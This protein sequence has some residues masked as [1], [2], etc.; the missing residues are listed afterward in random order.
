MERLQEIHRLEKKADRLQSLADRRA[1]INDIRLQRF[2]AA[3]DNPVMQFRQAHAIWLNNQHIS[4]IIPQ[5]IEAIQEQQ[6]AIS[7]EGLAE[8][9]EQGLILSGGYER[10]SAEHQIPVNPQ[11]Q[12]EPQRAEI[13]PHE[14]KP[15]TQR[16]RHEGKREVFAVTLPDGQILESTSKRI[17]KVLEMLLL[18]PADTQ[19]LAIAIYQSYDQATIFKIF[20]ALSNTRSKINPLGWDIITK[21]TAAERSKGKK[22]IYELVR[23]EKQEKA[24]ET[25]VSPQSEVEANP[26]ML[27]LEEGARLAAFIHAYY[28]VLSQLEGFERIPLG[29]FNELISSDA[30]IKPE[31]NG[32]RIVSRDFTLATIQKVRRIIEGNDF[33]E[34]CELADIQLPNL[35]AVFEY[36][37]LMHNE[38]PAFLPTLEKI[39]TEGV[40]SLTVEERWSDATHGYHVR[41]HHIE[42]SF[43]LEGATTSAAVDTHDAQST[44]R[45]AHPATA[46]AT[47]IT[48]TG[49]YAVKEGTPPAES[50]LNG[51]Q[52]QVEQPVADA[53]VETPIIPVPLTR[54]K[55]TGR[56]A[57]AKGNAGPINTGIKAPETGH[58]AARTPKNGAEE[59]FPNANRIIG[60]TIQTLLD[61][62]V[63]F[64]QII[65][66]AEVTKILGIRRTYQEQLEG[67]GVIKLTV[68]RRSSAISISFENAVRLAVFKKL[69]GET[70]SPTAKKELEDLIANAIDRA[71]K[72]HS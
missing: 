42:A 41:D 44:D 70:L 53:T 40:D 38:N 16:P 47:P 62:G 29:D 28:P 67:Q 66:T 51:A 37:I 3:K 2:L 49:D 32:K 54:R 18:G 48:T 6:R 12:E 34:C 39:S 25:P 46:A 20:S 60:E 30:D 63:K 59:R 36:V 14:Q 45:S 69:N 61:H 7:A 1:E 58:K 31:L 65:S 27:T 55:R 19:T 56:T 43:P 22:A 52:V 8:Y 68:K 17:A 24:P 21:T 50:A 35:R 71:Q 33:G 4:T 13:A 11:P 23:M 15:N 57:H 10:N 26:N 72:N 64:D 5:K 9:A